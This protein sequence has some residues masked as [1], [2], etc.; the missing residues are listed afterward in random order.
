MFIMKVI[1][2]FLLCLTFSQYLFAQDVDMDS[3]QKRTLIIHDG[4]VISEE[5]EVEVY[6]YHTGTFQTFKVYRQ[7][8]K[9]LKEADA[10]K[11]EA[12]VKPQ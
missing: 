10:K 4:K 1:L 5:H 2:G 7:P 8:E 9:K 6:D 12:T 3:D 11:P